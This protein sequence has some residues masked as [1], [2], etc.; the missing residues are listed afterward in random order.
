MGG[1]GLVGTPPGAPTRPPKQILNKKGIELI[2]DVT[3][4]L[5]RKRLSM[6]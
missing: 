4:V 6:G 2:G 1:G 3:W 5:M